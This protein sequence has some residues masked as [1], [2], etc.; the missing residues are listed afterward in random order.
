MFKPQH[1]F[2]LTHHQGFNTFTRH[3][4]HLFGHDATVFMDSLVLVFKWVITYG[5]AHF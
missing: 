5:T 4:Q 3:T 1:E 2:G